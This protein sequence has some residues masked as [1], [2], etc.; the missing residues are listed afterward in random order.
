MIQ[1][2]FQLTSETAVFFKLPYLKLTTLRHRSVR[3]WSFEIYLP[4]NMDICSR[5][6]DAAL[7][8][9]DPWS[10]VNRSIKLLTVNVCHLTQFAFLWSFKAQHGMLI[11]DKNSSSKYIFLFVFFVS[12]LTTTAIANYFVSNPNI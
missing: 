10:H 3:K 2:F 4:N 9:P 12:C 8:C 11:L 6:T 5:R 1:Q 7:T